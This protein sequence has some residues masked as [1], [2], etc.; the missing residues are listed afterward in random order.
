MMPPRES[1]PRILLRDAGNF[2]GAIREV[3]AL[4]SR[5]DAELPALLALRSF[6]SASKAAHERDRAAAL[7]DID[8]ALPGARDRALPAGHVLAGQFLLLSGDAAGARA[9]ADRILRDAADHDGANLLRGWVEVTSGMATHVHGMGPLVSACSPPP[10]PGA[11][12]GPVPTTSAAGS[13]AG[14]GGG[15]SSAAAGEEVDAAAIRFERV[16]QAHAPGGSGG[17]SGSGPQTYHF[18]D[19]AMGLAAAHERR[20]DY[21]AAGACR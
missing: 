14:G 13:S 21:G 1:H 2:A 4:R 15:P 18:L 16:M 9:S 5:R 10:A 7:A 8:A 17:A 11:L 6:H 20:G 12:G 19:S 3:E